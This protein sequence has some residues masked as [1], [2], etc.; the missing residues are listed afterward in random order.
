MDG[1]PHYPTTKPREAKGK[2][3]DKNEFRGR[4]FDK[5]LQSVRSMPF[6]IRF[7]SSLCTL[8]RFLVTEKVIGPNNTPHSKK[9][10]NELEKKKSPANNCSLLQVGIADN[11]HHKVAVEED[12]AVRHKEVGEEGLLEILVVVGLEANNQVLAQNRAAMAVEHRTEVAP[13]GTEA[14]VD[15]LLV[16]HM[17][18]ESHSD[19]GT[20]LGVWHFDSCRVEVRELNEPHENGDPNFQD[21]E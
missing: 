18:F 16:L 20:A 2:E 13:L 7:Y 4:D 9:V 3:W 12:I 19:A 10:I 6:L 15:N 17:V 8:C 21:G 14:L 1:G 11:L 5:M